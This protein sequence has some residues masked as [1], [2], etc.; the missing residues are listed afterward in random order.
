MGSMLFGLA[1]IKRISIPGYVKQPA[2]RFDC[3]IQLWLSISSL[4]ELKRFVIP[5]YVKQRGSIPTISTYYLKICFTLDPKVVDSRPTL[6]FNVA[7]FHTWL[8]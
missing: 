5:S 2:T 6:D 3:S 1:P 4:R 8:G 7:D